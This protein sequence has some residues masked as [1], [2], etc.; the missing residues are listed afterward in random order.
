MRSVPICTARQGA[1]TVCFLR[2]SLY[3]GVELVINRLASQARIHQRHEA[4]GIGNGVV[5]I[6]HLSFP[7]FF[8]NPPI[9]THFLIIWVPPYHVRPYS[10]RWFRLQDVLP[11]DDFRFSLCCL[12]SSLCLTPRLFKRALMISERSMEIVPT[13][14]GC[15]VW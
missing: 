8:S 7:A 10:L 4:C 5:F 13:S 9:P 2:P 1:V 14:T 15:P 3:T 6:A 12:A 11:H